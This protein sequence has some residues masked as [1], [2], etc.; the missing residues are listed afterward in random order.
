MSNSRPSALASA[1]FWEP[2]YE[3]LVELVHQRD[4]DARRRLVALVLDLY[5]ASG[6]HLDRL[7]PDALA[8]VVDMSALLGD[9]S[10]R[11]MVV[12]EA[13]YDAAIFPYRPHHYGYLH[14]RGSATPALYYA[15]SATLGGVPDRVGATG[16]NNFETYVFRRGP[17]AE[18]Y[19]LL[20]GNLSRFAS[21]RADVVGYYDDRRMAR[22][23]T[24][25]PKAHVAVELPA[26]YEGRALSRVELKSLFRLASYVVGRQAGTGDLRLFDHLFT[27]FR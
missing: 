7:E 3:H 1:T 14:R 20:V 2:G 23:V 8:E 25:A 6:K 12:F 5:D 9:R 10:E 26:T 18:E 24:L 15:V 17:F 19:S 4:A 16:L 27:Y 21:A 11:V 22:T 13:R